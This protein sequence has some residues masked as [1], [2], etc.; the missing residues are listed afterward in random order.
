MNL[1]G[2]A[3]RDALKP[4]EFGKE[5]QKKKYFKTKR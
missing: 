5:K 1:D 2:K 4:C 3:K